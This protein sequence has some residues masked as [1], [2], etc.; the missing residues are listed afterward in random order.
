M[1]KS[2]LI[3]T[4]CAVASAAFGQKASE[5]DLQEITVTGTSI[6]GAAPIGQQLTTIDSAA[7]QA[8][9][10]T[11]TA[12][13]LASVPLLNSFNIAPQGGQSE[14][15]SGGS[16]TPGLHGLPG[17][18]TLVL[19]DGHRGVGD[20]PLLNV[21]DPSSI[22]P[23]AIDH[24]EIVADGGSAIYGSDAVAGVINI[25]LKK[26]FEGAETTGSYG[27]AS[28]YNQT[29][30]GQTFGKT[31]SGGSALIAATYAANTDLKNSD[32]R[33]YQTAPAGLAFNPVVNC[34][35]PN[36]VINGT[37]YAGSGLIA[38]PPNTC[39]PNRDAD[40][41][42]QD[43]RYAVIADV[44]Q[45]VGERVHLSLD[46]KYTDDLS[47]EQIAQVSNQT[48]TL[49]NT[50]PFFALPP[51]V[52]ASSESVLW[53]TGNLNTPLFDAFRSKSGLLDIGADIDLGRAWR[54][55]TD[56]DYGW[57]SSSAL[58]SD[59]GGV[60]ITALNAAVNAT[61]LA[62]ALDPFSNRTKPNVAAGI[63]NYPLWFY[64]EQKLWDF[65]LKVDG[66]IF[67]LPGGDVKIA[68]GAGNRHEHYSGSDPIGLP[69]DPDYTN[70]TVDVSRSVSA[71]F[72]EV[73]VPIFGSSNAI[74]G[75]QRLNLSLAGRF[76]HYS[77]FGNTKNPKYG[78]DWTP[79]EGVKL[80]ASYGTSF[81]AP[82]LADIY[83]IDTRSGGTFPSTPPPGF[84][85]PAGANYQEAY[86]AGGRQGLQ[87]ENAK[88]ASF[89]LDLT[90]AEI[91]GFKA[92]VSYWMVRFTNEV[93][94]PISFN[95]NL[96]SLLS[97]F[98]NL[99]VVN[100]ATGLLGP[101]T[102]AQFNSILQGIRLTGALTNVPPPQVWEI[103][104]ARRA[105]IGATAIDGI[106]FDFSYQY[107]LSSGTLLMGLSGEYLSQYESN[108]GPGTAYQD[109]LKN[110]SSTQSSDSS[111]Y[112]VIPWHLRGTLGWQAGPLA[113][114]AALNYTG[115]YNFG[116]T[117]PCGA[118]T[119]STTQW[120]SPFITTD[121][122]ASYQLPKD[123]R[124]Q[125]NL[126]NLLNEH[127]PVI[128]A[129]GGFSTLSANPLGRLVRLSVDKRW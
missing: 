88:T 115:H 53:N 61:T 14:F 126:D 41:Y 100:P 78:I 15:N 33:F 18:A 57:S 76:D 11:N 13:L 97:R 121:L 95:L 52:V 87:P 39:D 21:P 10:A 91:P 20:T 8:V 1:N 114:Q 107:P 116:Y 124:I 24:I 65:N 54:L 86:I 68:I 96:P 119:C 50:N 45:D 123:L 99:N 64:G 17:T 60:N 98:V 26:N 37:N 59:N 81:H 79:I 25:I 90:P 109:N 62:T 3:L 44:R 111:A 110:G 2:I 43:R 102:S 19:I 120:V 106:D 129:A 67:T 48:I 127:P 51:G 77:D 58:N 6:R 32:R 71:V 74:T 101:L 94:I 105:N 5:D 16:S 34:N 28:P 69:G 93:Q 108:A 104:D 38:G 85:L 55:S 23:S 47:Q 103:L 36:V 56:L 112:N 22:P 27:A 73:A 40:L 66:P 46:A 12:D 113:A 75:V 30:L 9:G 83:G 7:I 82:Q 128:E 29:S 118:T 70:N 122:V 89:G 4:L 80:R 117:T 63:L 42:N 72:G 31:W 92:S 35:P 125:V 49:P 84:L